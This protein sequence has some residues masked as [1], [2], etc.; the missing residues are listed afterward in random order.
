MIFF[1]KS[2]KIGLMENLI[3]ELTA[4][5]TEYVHAVTKQLMLAGK[6]DEEVKTILNEILPQI[7]EGQKTNV[8]ARKLLGTPTEFV[9]QYVPKTVVDKKSSADVNSNEKPVLMWLDSTLLF[10]G[11]IYLMTG[12]M[13][14]FNAKGAQAYGLTTTFIMAALAGLVMFMIYKFYYAQAQGK[15]KW[16]WKSVLLIVVVVLIWSAFTT[17]SQFLPAVLNPVLN[18]Y[19]TLAIAV[20]ALLAKYLLKRKFHIRSSLAPMS[21][22]QK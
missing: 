17:F 22:G 1:L 9:E 5:N 19:A 7:I 12:V 18:A 16:N 6:T 14:L 10:F 8:L 11:L 3:E 20:I 2:D 13:A 21:N 4:K 15:R